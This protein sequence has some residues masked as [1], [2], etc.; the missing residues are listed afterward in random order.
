M[1]LTKARSSLSSPDGDRL[2]GLRVAPTPL[3]FHATYLQSVTQLLLATQV[4]SIGE[5]KAGSREL[6]RTESSRGGAENAEEK[7]TD[8]QETPLAGDQNESAED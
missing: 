7:P 4:T 3:F 5:R 1:F 8:N 6:K 2:Y